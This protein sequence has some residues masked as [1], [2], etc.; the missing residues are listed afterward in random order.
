MATQGRLVQPAR[1]V[2]RARRAKRR[3]LIAGYQQLPV[4]KG[5]KVSQ[6]LKASPVRKVHRA[7]PGPPAC[8][9]CRVPWARKAPPV[10]SGPRVTKAPLG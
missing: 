1:Q 2:R 7:I 6:G 5:L 4:H 10:H 8:P 3:K 9:E